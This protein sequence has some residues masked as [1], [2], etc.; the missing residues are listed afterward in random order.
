MS[1]LQEFIN[2]D[3][4]GIKSLRLQFKFGD[5]RTGAGRFFR[6]KDGLFILE[7]SDRWGT[8]VCPI[9]R[10]LDEIDTEEK[11]IAICVAAAERE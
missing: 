2:L 6:R 3:P 8:Y 11:M 10:R 5:H 9:K 7:I 1:R 4:K